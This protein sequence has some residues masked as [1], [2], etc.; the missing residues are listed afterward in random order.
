MKINCIVCDSITTKRLVTLRDSSKEEINACPD[1]GFEYFDFSNN[2]E[3]IENDQMEALRLGSVGL[4]IPD[5]EEDF[6]NGYNQSE[7]YIIKYIDSESQPREVLEIGCS[8]GYF[9][10]K[11]KEKNI[12]CIGVEKN[13]VRQKYVEEE[14]GLRCYNDLIKVEENNIYFDKIFMFYTFEY[15]TNPL[16]YIKRLIKL[17][18]S[19]GQIVIYTPNLS[20]VLK[21][22]WNNQAFNNFFYEKQS[23]GYYTIESIRRLIER[24]K[25]KD[26]SYQIST[27]QGYSFYNHLSWY[28]TN[29]PKFTGIVGGDNFTNEIISTFKQDNDIE[30]SLKELILKFDNEYKKTVEKFKCG[31]RIILIIDKK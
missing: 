7:Q 6:N 13:P 4:K 17:L 19:N 18:K 1:C 8:W 11:L 12:N 30:Q 29:K 3:A 10:S 25:N 26:I 27:E 9:L 20:D 28:L 2:M 16:K 24:A 5:I 15:I 31:N 22:S 21:D 14:I 23:V